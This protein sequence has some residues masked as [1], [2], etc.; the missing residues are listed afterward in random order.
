M[1]RL[2]FMFPLIALS[3]M[4]VAEISE[5]VQK[6][7]ETAEAA[8]Q[9]AVAKAEN[10]KFYAVQ[11][12]GAD[13]VKI[14]KQ[15]MTEATKS[16]DL[17]G[18]TKL[19]DLVAAAE[20]AGAIRAKPKDVVKFGG[21]EYALIPEGA[22]WIVAKRICEQMGGHLVCIESP[23]EADFIV[24]LCRNR[25][26][27]IGGTDEVVEGKWVWINGKPVELKLELD[28]GGPAGSD[29]WIAIFEGKWHDGGGGNRYQFVCE[30]EK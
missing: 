5:K 21:H 8:F 22:P 12:A 20:Q 14:L 4:A 1:R 27:W 16:G 13:R 25:T 17:D 11:K 18:A 6:K 19:K 29:H 2:V 9:Q 28:N 30:W 10:A 7:L 3:T 26:A 23:Q 15:L 24:G